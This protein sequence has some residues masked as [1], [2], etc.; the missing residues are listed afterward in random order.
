M[1]NTTLPILPESLN[2]L[3][4]RFDIYDAIK[5]VYEIYLVEY[6]SAPAKPKEP[7]LKDGVSAAVIKYGEDFKAWEQAKAEYIERRSA[8]Q[9][10]N[11]KVNRLIESFI[12]DQSGL[13]NIPIQYRDKVYSHAYSD[14]HSD[15]Y[16]TV[17]QKL[18]SLVEIFE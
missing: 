11:G 16:Y 9:K 2:D 7:S 5:H 12:K 3:A 15:G 8:I 4:A 17:Y 6:P 18:C 13:D 10:H 14:G 1:E